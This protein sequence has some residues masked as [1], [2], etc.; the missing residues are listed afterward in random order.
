MVGYLSAA[1]PIELTPR[2]TRMATDQTLV[3]RNNAFAANFQY[4]DLEIKPRLSTLIVGCVDSRVDPVHLLGLEPGDAVVMRNVGGRVTDE[5]IEHIKILEA[6]GSLMMGVTMDVALIHHT[7]CG[8]SLFTVPQVAEALTQALQADASVIESLAIDDPV[9]SIHTDI[10]RLRSA[11]VL[12]DEMLVAG[13]VYDVGDG[14]LTEIVAQTPLRG[15][16]E[17]PS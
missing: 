2:R 10:D 4:A 15:G 5:V 11:E 6:L 8:A 12:S 14:R 1:T 16:A 3:E 13:Y 17:N 9:E 7:G